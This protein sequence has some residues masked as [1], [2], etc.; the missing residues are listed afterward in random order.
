MCI[1]VPLRI[2]SVDG[3]A[4]CA[5]DGVEE[6]LID[7]SL[8]GP[9]APG[10]WVLSFLGTAREE[11]SAEEAAVIADALAGLRAVMTGGDVGDAFAD[12]DART[13]TL[14]PHLQAAF[15][16]GDRTG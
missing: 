12:L 8:T 5:T 15:D 9:L 10:A 16:N 2:L 4:A 3:I 11:I 14:P 6:L 1:G 7:L 13:P